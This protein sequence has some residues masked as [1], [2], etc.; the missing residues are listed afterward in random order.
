MSDAACGGRSVHVHSPSRTSPWPR[1]RFCSWTAIQSRT[2]GNVVAALGFINYEQTVSNKRTV[3][4]NDVFS[5]A[6]S[7]SS[8]KKVGEQKYFTGR[9]D[10][11][12]RKADSLSAQSV[13]W[14]D[15]AYRLSWEEFYGRLRL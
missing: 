13:T 5:E 4:G 1:A 6:I 11:L 3:N 2:T 9:E 12:V 7:L 10:V 15:S 8:L 14:S